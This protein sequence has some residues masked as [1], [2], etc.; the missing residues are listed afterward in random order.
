MQIKDLKKG[1]YFKLVKKDGTLSKIVYVRE[2]YIRETKKYWCSKFE[3]IG[4]GREFSP[5]T[6]VSVDFEF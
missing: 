1:E 5:K 3:D 6:K 4:D 2:H